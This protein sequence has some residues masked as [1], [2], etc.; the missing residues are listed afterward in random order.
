MG[1][2]P[3]RGNLWR[4]YG[5]YQD[6]TGVGCRENLLQETQNCINMTNLL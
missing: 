5:G 4:E 3:S 1:D 6:K 2:S